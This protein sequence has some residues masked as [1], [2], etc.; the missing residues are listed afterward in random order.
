MWVYT[1]RAAHLINR[2]GTPWDSFTPI[3]YPA[4]LALIFKLFGVNNFTP[5]AIVHAFMGAGSVTL[6]HV[7]A[8]RVSGSNIVALASSLFIMF[9]PPL[10]LY[11]G[12]CLTELPSTFLLLLMTWALLV[13]FEKQN[14]W[15][16]ALCGVSLGV[17]IT[18]RSNVALFVPCVPVALW[19]SFRDRKKALVVAA[20]SLAWAAPV[21]LVA[22]VH[23]SGLRGKFVPFSTNGGMNFF[24][25]HAEYSAVRFKDP[26]GASH[27]IMP[28]P[29][30]LRYKAYSSRPSLLQRVVFLL[31]GHRYTRK[32]PFKSDLGA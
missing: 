27:Q 24:L 7:I 25:A 8:R 17:A 18:V 13:A 31:E 28:I 5:L 22:S 2:D 4:F 1:F 23:M 32:Q 19:A 10:V 6:T 12:L 11:G 20:K 9:Y 21:L 26:T 16:L 15:L 3:G 14:H 30:M 29:N